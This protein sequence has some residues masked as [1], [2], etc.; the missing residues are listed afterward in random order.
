MRVDFPEP[1]D[2]IILYTPGGLSETFHPQIESTFFE[3]SKESGWILFNSIFKV[4]RFVISLQ[5][6]KLPAIT[7]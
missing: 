2:A 3:N 1:L 5:F 4:I 7:Q 6:G